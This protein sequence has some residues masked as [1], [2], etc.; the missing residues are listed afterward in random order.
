M[1]QKSPPFEFFD[2]LQQNLKEK[3]KKFQVFFKKSFA[4][5]SLRYSADFRRFRLVW[6]YGADESFLNYCGKG[7][8][9]FGTRTFFEKYFIC[10]KDTPSLIYM[11]SEPKVSFSAQRFFPKKKV[12]EIFFH[13]EFF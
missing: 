2:I 8:V 13:E 4:F 9:F 3:N 11:F 7:V 10:S 6:S 12:F 5:L 1:S